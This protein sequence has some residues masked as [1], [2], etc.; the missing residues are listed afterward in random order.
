MG[1][2]NSYQ[3]TRPP[4][5]TVRRLYTVALLFLLKIIERPQAFNTIRHGLAWTDMVILFVPGWWQCLIMS[6]KLW[7][8]WLALTNFVFFICIK[9]WSPCQ[10]QEGHS[11][12][13]QSFV[14]C[15]STWKANNIFN[16]YIY[17]FIG[18][19]TA[20]D[21]LT[22]I[23]IVSNSMCV[24]TCAPAPT[25]SKTV[26]TKGTRPGQ[27]FTRPAASPTLL[28]VICGHSRTYDPAGFN[29]WIHWHYNTWM[30]P[31][32]AGSMQTIR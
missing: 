10:G 13:D 19:V 30:M 8:A 11:Y 5:E 32:L 16:I 12:V 2:Q 9:V 28:L 20:L 27:I 26:H 21:H 18:I 7:S 6:R 15:W 3:A 24:E 25:D 4:S 14:L 1:T 17:V 31:L 22:D 23:Y 29:D